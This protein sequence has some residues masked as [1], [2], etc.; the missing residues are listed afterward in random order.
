MAKNVLGNDLKICCENPITGFFRNGRCDTSPEDLGM[1]TVCVFVTQEFLEFSFS[2]G[3][4]LS[5]P[6]PEYGF[7]GLTPGDK[8]CLCL[9]RWVEAHQAGI[10]PNIDLEASHI[11]ILEHVE[12]EELKKY[13]I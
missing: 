10:A 11:S 13:A 7:S 2:K 5:T 9:M 6:I 3:N 12:F 8:W 4:D 1:H